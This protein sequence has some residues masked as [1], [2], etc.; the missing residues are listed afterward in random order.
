[1]RSAFDRDTGRKKLRI[2]ALYASAAGGGGETFGQLMKV[3]SDASWTNYMEVVCN[4]AAAIYARPM[5]YVQ[6]VERTESSTMGGSGGVDADAAVGGDADEE[7]GDADLRRRADNFEPNEGVERWW[8]A[9][10]DCHEYL[11]DQVEEVESALGFLTGKKLN[12][13]VGPAISLPNRRPTRR[14]WTWR[15]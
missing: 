12:Y 14:S 2:E 8:A 11:A 4:P 6:F 15:T 1:M 3:S 7:V 9:R 5:V 13:N 10:I